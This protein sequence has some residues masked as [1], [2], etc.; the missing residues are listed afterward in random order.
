MS[1][2][3]TSVVGL[4]SGLSHMIKN[5]SCAKTVRLT[6]AVCYVKKG[7]QA[8]LV[9]IGIPK[10]LNMGLWPTA[11]ERSV[12]YSISKLF[13]GSKDRPRRL[14][15]RPPGSPLDGLSHFPRSDF[16]PPCFMPE[17]RLITYELC[18]SLRVPEFRLSL[19]S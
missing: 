1:L 18:V 4:K 6:A 19:T 3:S 13:A 2:R 11:P 9:Q 15:L 12:L 8:G 14:Q 5:P 17:T 16:L 10:R 7:T